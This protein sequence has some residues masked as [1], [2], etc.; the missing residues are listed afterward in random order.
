MVW[1]GTIYADAAKNTSC[2]YKEFLLR[3]IDLSAL[4]ERFFVDTLN[5]V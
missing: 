5:Y 2:H 3:Q 1:V 4:A